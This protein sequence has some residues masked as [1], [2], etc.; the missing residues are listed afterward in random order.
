[1]VASYLCNT[2]LEFWYINFRPCYIHNRSLSSIFYRGMLY[3]KQ[4]E[5]LSLLT[6]ACLFK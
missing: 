1:M 2:H 5:V 3:L 4:K 6:N